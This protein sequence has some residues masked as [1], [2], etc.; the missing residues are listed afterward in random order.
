VAGLTG[1]ARADRAVLT[2]A[3]EL[4]APVDTAHAD[5]PVVTPTHGTRVVST[6]DPDDEVR[7]VVRLV[8]DAAREGVPLERMAVLYGAPDPYARLVHE[9][10]AAAG[11]PHNGAAVRTLAGSVLGRGLLGL[12]ALPDRDYHRHDVMALLASVPVRHRGV[13]VPGSRWERVTRDAGIVRGAVQWEERLA[14]HRS[15]LE[16]ELQLELAVTE[17]EPRPARACG[18]SPPIS[19]AHSHRRPGGPGAGPTGWRGP[20]A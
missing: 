17:H 19:S 11:I 6:S 10:L 7:A 12:L 16:A 18:R 4:D 1:T 5:A 8:V 20:R 13:A 14:R 2:L 3:G 9:Q 15:V